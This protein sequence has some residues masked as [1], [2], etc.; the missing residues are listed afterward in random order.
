MKNRIK[1]FIEYIRSIKY[2]IILVKYK[3]LSNYNG[4]SSIQDKIIKNG[5][6]Q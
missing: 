4:V 3:E 5:K 2:N 1:I 6:H